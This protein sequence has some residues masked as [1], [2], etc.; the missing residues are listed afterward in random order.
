MLRVGLLPSE[1]RDNAFLQILKNLSSLNQVDSRFSQVIQSFPFVPNEK[2][3][4]CQPCSLYDPRN[5]DL[6]TLLDLQTSFPSASFCLD[7]AILPALQHLGLRQQPGL[8]TFL[9]AAR[10]V[11]RLGKEASESQI[12]PERMDE[13]VARGKAL[14]AYLELDSDRIYQHIPTPSSSSTK[15]A[16]PGSQLQRPGVLSS[17]PAVMGRLGLGLLSKVSGIFGS[18]QIQ[19]TV[20]QGQKSDFKPGCNE[21]IVNS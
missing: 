20:H 21:D 11:E 2:G 12:D 5:L 7:P 15:A 19:G 18:L 13:A 14:L 9:M 10:Y 17:A 16:I 1:I 8:D 3:E 4:L 6:V